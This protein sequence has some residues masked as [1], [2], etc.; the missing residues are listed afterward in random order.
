MEYAKKVRVENFPSI[1]AKKMP[2]PIDIIN[3]KSTHRLPE[4]KS[5][6]YI[7]KLNDIGNKYMKYSKE[8]TFSSQKV[9]KKLDIKKTDAM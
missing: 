5:P 4:L 7:R 3:D 9:L 8:R 6:E 2:L 1:Y